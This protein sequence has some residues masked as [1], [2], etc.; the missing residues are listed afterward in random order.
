MSVESAGV[1][2][3]HE[4]NTKTVQAS[5]LTFNELF[6]ANTQRAVEWNNGGRSPGIDFAGN[7]LA[8]EVGEL[9]SAIKRISRGQRGMRGG[10]SEEAGLPNVKEEL[11]DV[12]ICCSLIAKEFGINLGEAVRDK[13][14]ATSE[15]YN[16]L[17]RLP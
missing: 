8:A 7:E 12:V 4:N 14:N 11:G 13:F 5:D 17:T 16:F 3:K 9:C 15:K 10:C 1:P 6:R 2:S